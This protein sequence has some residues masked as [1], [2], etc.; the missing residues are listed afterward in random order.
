MWNFN[1]PQQ[2]HPAKPITIPRVFCGCLRLPGRTSKSSLLD[3]SIFKRS[4]SFGIVAC[5]FFDKKNPSFTRMNQPNGMRGNQRYF[6]RI[7]ELI[8]DL[9]RTK[10]STI[11]LSVNFLLK[12]AETVEPIQ[13]AFE[14]VP[15]LM[16]H[17]QPKM[18]SHSLQA[19]PW[20]AGTLNLEYF[21]L[22][23]K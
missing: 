20:G 22:D 14:E 5:S 10:P 4:L 13:R 21:S 18:I 17:L 8:V 11:P 16:T 9:K 6:V 19:W 12:N 23:L 3:Y 1:Q 2:T 15:S 7:L